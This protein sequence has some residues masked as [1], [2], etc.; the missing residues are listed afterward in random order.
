LHFGHTFLITLGISVT[1]I[2]AFLEVLHRSGVGHI[3]GN[4][5][6]TE[7]PLN[8]ALAGDSRFKYIF[9]LQE[10]AIITMAGGYAMAS[11]G[12][13]VANVHISCGLGNAMGMLYNA[14]CE[15][16]PLMLTV[17]HQDQRLRLGEPVLEGDVVRVARPWTK[18]SAEVHRVEDIPTAVRRAIQTALTPPAGPVFLALPL[19]LQMQSCER[20]DLSP[21][22]V[23]DR[24]VRPP[25]EALRRAAELLAEAKNPVILA[26]SRVVESGGI[27]DL[28]ALA[29][30]LGAPV[31]AEAATSHGRLPMAADHPLYFGS[32]PLWSP[33]VHELLAPFDVALAV[34][35]NVLRMYLYHEPERTIPGQLSIVHLDSDPWQIGKN[36]P[37]ELGLLGD[38]QA[39][40]AELNELL[41]QR[42]DKTHTAAAEA[43]RRQYAAK[44]EADRRELLARIDDER[45]RRPMT[46][47][48]LMEA[49]ARALPP[50]AVVVEEA[51]TTHHTL[52]EKL[53][54]FK[55]PTGHFAHRGWA[56]GWGLGTALGVKLAWPDRPVVG[57]L[58][59]GAAMYG[60]QGLWSAAHHNI[61][62]TF[63][64]AN[65]SQYK[66]LKVCGDVM[67]LE[68]LSD[69][70]CP[71]IN[72]TGPAIDFVG[73]SRA[74]GVEA[75]QVAEPDELTE[76]LRTSF[77]RDKPLLLEV[78]QAG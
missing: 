8:A 35:M 27:D 78:P 17:G 30:R 71:G 44:R 36:Y 40:L 77:A 19:D 6:T 56:L 39:G 75:H 34:G 48:V 54:T 59:D 4:P 57:L 60:I 76:R 10:I 20:F 11:G 23:L 66:I 74:L 62:V 29:E 61:P 51:I 15:G 43:R 18:W 24:R 26:G 25:A 13:G 9:G 47:M 73:L 21:A 32:L 41:A 16:T 1:G 14:H 5:G 49:L 33:D 46:P 69:P 63:V 45:P 22:H 31:F 3:F 28:T 55:D 7:L 2:E 58:G 12:V 42:L 53:G 65:N 37:V 52:L 68:N 72:L 67:S 50:K 64:I 38:P 70:A